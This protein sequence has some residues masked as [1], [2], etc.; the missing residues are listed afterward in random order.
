M[1]TPKNADDDDISRCFLAFARLS[2]YLQFS[3]RHSREMSKRSRRGRRSARAASSIARR[4]S[5]HDACGAR[6]SVLFEHSRWLAV[7]P[8]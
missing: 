8:K 2:S 1:S 5:I 6:F 3:G 7:A 4:R